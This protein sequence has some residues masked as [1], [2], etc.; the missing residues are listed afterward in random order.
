MPKN[1][2]LY[3]SFCILITINICLGILQVIIKHLIEEVI[4]SQEKYQAILL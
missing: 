2:K 4:K 1:V 3:I